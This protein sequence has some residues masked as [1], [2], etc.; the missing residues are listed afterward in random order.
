MFLRG[1]KVLVHSRFKQLKEQEARRKQQ[2]KEEKRKAEEA[3]ASGSQITNGGHNKEAHL[4]EREHGAGDDLIEDRNRSVESV[5]TIRDSTTNGNGAI[6]NGNYSS[7]DLKNGQ[8]TASTLGRENS[9]FSNINKVDE[10][11]EQLTFDELEKG[12]HTEHALK[13]ITFSYV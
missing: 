3:A 5:T 9:D 1:L 8:E 6:V 2:R 11:D 7:Q 4:V 12:I 10:P 13:Y